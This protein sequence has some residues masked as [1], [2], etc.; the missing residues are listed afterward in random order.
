M[1]GIHTL[2]LI[3][4]SIAIISPSA[5][6]QLVPAG[7]KA[8]LTVEYEFVSSGVRQDKYDTQEWKVHRLAVILLTL[9]AQKPTSLPALHKVE[10]GQR[11]DIAER[12]AAMD[13]AAKTMQ[14]TMADMMQIAERCGLFQ[15]RFNNAGAV[16]GLDEDGGGHFV[17]SYQEAPIWAYT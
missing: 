15:N 10:D 14:P 2:L 8:E 12:Q 7:Q 4:T 3:G 5:V 11:N 9:Q 6:A 16:V 17:Y 1:K 13:R